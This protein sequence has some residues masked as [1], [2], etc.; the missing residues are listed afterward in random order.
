[1]PFL[2]VAI[3]ALHAQHFQ[4]GRCESRQR[5]KYVKAG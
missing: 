4:T 2:A 1:V 3:D 5:R